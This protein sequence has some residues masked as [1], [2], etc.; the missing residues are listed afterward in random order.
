MNVKVCAY[1]GDGKFFHKLYKVSIPALYLNMVNAGRWRE[2]CLTVAYMEDM[3]YF[4]FLV[5]V[6]FTSGD[7]CTVMKTDL[8]KYLSV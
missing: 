6:Y 2:V 1:E 8:Q 5:E 3:N 7:S 4:C